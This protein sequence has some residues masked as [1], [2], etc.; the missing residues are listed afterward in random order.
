[1]AAVLETSMEPPYR[2]RMI[3][4]TIEKL[5][6]PIFLSDCGELLQIITSVLSGWEI[7]TAAP[8]SLQDPII[9]IKKTINGYERTSPWLSQPIVF[10]NSVNAVCDLIVDLIKYYISENQSLLCLHCAAVQ[11]GGGLIVF[12]STYNAGKSTLAAHLAAAGMNLFADDVMPINGDDNRGVAPGIQPRLRLPL[13]ENTDPSFRNFIDQMCGPKSQR[14]V[15]LNLGQ[16]KLAPLGTTAT[17]RG[18]VLLRRTDEGNATLA[19][20]RKSEVLKNAVLRNFS[21]DVAAVDV[22]DRLFGLVEGADCYTLNYSSP[23]DAVR[24]LDEAFGS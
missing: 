2:K 19:S 5:P 11:I 9:T 16:D 18:F 17:I 15:Y 8:P 7:K 12:P 21:R 6:Q 14:F 1:M 10:E 4:L 20:V 3:H 22:L 24:L 23:N 13:P